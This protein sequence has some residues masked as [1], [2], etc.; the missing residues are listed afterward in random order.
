MKKKKFN[1]TV[2]CKCLY[3]GEDEILNYLYNDYT[4]EDVVECAKGLL[5]V[6]KRANMLCNFE[7]IGINE[8]E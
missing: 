8:V 6:L 3:D 5:K 1:V 7:L 4:L 2:L